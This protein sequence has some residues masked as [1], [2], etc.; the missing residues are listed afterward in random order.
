[1]QLK[2]IEAAAKMARYICMA[3]FMRLGLELGNTSEH[4]RGPL[5]VRKENVPLQP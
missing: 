4:T 5:L 1:M 3:G 2:K